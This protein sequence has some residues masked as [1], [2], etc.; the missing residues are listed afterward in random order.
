MLKNTEISIA[1]DYS[2]LTEPE[3]NEHIKQSPENLLTLVLSLITSPQKT[4]DDYNHT[5]IYMQLENHNQFLEYLLVL[6]YLVSGQP[7]RGEE[8]VATRYRNTVT[9]KRN[10]F[11]FG[12][13]MV[14]AL[15]Y[16]KSPVEI[17][18]SETYSTLFSF[19]SQE[20]DAGISIFCT[21]FC[22]MVS[23]NFEGAV[24]SSIALDLEL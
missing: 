10:I 2:F 19:G 23:G 20:V 14:F 1:S 16:H 15:T 9:L 11:M 4:S 5:A 21:P 18:I 7:P 17:Q 8:L 12:K 13:D 22:C 6:V 3:Y 24:N